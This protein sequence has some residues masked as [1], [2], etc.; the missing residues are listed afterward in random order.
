LSVPTLVL[1]Y[2]AYLKLDGG[3]VMLKLA[4]MLD[5]ELN[6][7]GINDYLA[8]LQAFSGSRDVVLETLVSLLALS[9]RDIVSYLHRSNFKV[10]DSK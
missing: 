1:Y 3:I 4:Q 7:L 2:L 8:A 9:L 6:F 5:G 10:S